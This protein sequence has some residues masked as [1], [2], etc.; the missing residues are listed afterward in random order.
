[1]T[2][3]Q[4]TTND[5]NIVFFG[6]PEFGA[7]IL[8][9]LIK[10]GYVPQLVV[11]RPDKPI[12]KNSIPQPSAPIQSGSAVARTASK[13]N[14]MLLKPLKLKD[15]DFISQLSTVGSRLF[16]VA[17]YGKI[18]PQVVLDIPKLGNI[19]VHG[20]L[21]PKYRG[22]S[23]IQSAI[24]EGEDQT[25]I[26]IMLM[27]AEMDHGQVISQAALP[28]KPDNTF[29]SLSKKMAKLGADLLVKTIPKYIEWKTSGSTISG[30]QLAISSKL[31]LP[32]KQQDHTQ[33]TFT[34]ILT[35]EDGFVDLENLPSS[36]RFER[37]TRAY[38]P[39]PGVW[40]R[41]AISSQP[42]API[43][44]GSA[45]SKI[46]KFLPGKMIQIEGKKPM[47]Y[48]AF[49]NGHPQLKAAIQKLSGQS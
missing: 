5:L 44:S 24:L 1:M 18:I 14:I 37:M 3:K 43:K 32:P 13:Y 4:S 34:K 28:I 2:N 49:T 36:D 9:G 41:I 31:F 21:L 40:T 46:M 48:K 23:P 12:G 30:K 42:S 38:Y 33:A 11:T 22:A 45:V 16:I 8:E 7:T 15:P 39:W 27:D 20:S 26:T 47:D 25:G 29:P 10:A 17:S 6:T 35:R 19:N